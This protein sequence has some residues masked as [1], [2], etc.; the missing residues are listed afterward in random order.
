VS[1]KPRAAPGRRSD[2]LIGRPPV[3]RTDRVV[4]W[5]VLPVVVAL[6]GLLASERSE[7]TR[8]TPR[9][10]WE[11]PRVTAPCETMANWLLDQLPARCAAFYG[12]GRLP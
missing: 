4:L 7:L 10:L 6:V 3:D 12:I 9:W 1:D 2:Q 8:L 11:Q 5:L